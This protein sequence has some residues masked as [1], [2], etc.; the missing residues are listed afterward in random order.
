MPYYFNLS[1]NESRWEPPSGTDT[2]SL[3]DYLAQNF[4]PH[5]APEKIRVRHLLIKH[6]GS[7]RPSS[8]KEVKSRHPQ[9]NPLP[10]I[11]LTLRG[12]LLWANCYVGK[13]NPHARR[14]E[15]NPLR[16]R[17]AHKI[18][19]H[20]SRRVSSFRERLQQCS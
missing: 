6:T 9:N 14:S 15:V 17:I 12:C 2:N 1:T 8:W 19:Q 3:K 11:L 20:H 16:A 18:R 4:K 13:N 10:K 5:P 7:R